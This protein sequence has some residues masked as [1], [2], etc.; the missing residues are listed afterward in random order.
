MER[1]PL[2]SV[3]P[4]PPPPYP[5]D[6]FA[7][8]SPDEWINQEL[9]VTKISRTDALLEQLQSRDAQKRRQAIWELGQR[10]T[11]DA[12]QPLVDALVDSDSQQRSLI[13]GAIAEI[14]TRTLS[15]IN[16]ALMISLQDSNTDVRKNAIRDL[17]RIYTLMAQMSQILAHAALDRDAEVQATA[18]WA[19]E[20]FNQVCHPSNLRVLNASETH[21]VYPLPPGSQEGS[22]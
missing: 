10:G 18:L 21:P 17:T 7:P 15:P 6:R 22:G 2:S 20:E 19:L 8:G 13:L 14:G 4:P 9:S 5:A 3:P 12:I 11:S 1:S 16:H